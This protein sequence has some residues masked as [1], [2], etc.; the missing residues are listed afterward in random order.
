MFLLGNAFRL[1]SEPMVRK[2]LLRLVRA[3]ALSS[4][5]EAQDWLDAWRGGAPRVVRA[6]LEK[7]IKKGHRRAR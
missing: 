5:D 3:W 2:G 4:P 6:E 1:D 7:A